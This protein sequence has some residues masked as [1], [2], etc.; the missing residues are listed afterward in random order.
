MPVL[1]FPVKTPLLHAFVTQLASMCLSSCLA[2]MSARHGE[3]KAPVSGEAA[4]ACDDA[5][6]CA[7][8]RMVEEFPME[9]PILPYLFA[10]AVGELGFRDVWSRTR[11]YAESVP[12]VLDGAAREFERTEDMT[13][14]GEKLFGPYEWEKFDLLVLPPSYAYG[15]MVNPRMERLGTQ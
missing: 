1:Y 13:R 11:V 5:L 7:E 8:R 15:G 12:A 10:F 9:Q 4:M 14:H 6:W 3:R 2:V